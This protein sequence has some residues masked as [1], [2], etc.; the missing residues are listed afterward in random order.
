[1][2]TS[3]AGG[4]GGTIPSGGGLLAPSKG[5]EPPG[6]SP[7]SQQVKITLRSSL[8]SWE[9]PLP[10]ERGPTARSRDDKFSPILSVVLILGSHSQKLF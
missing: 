9:A 5:S 6:H 4:D 10:G 7:I 1:M 8:R 3:G 2:S